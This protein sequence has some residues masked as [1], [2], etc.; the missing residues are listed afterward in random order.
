MLLF[1][2]FDKPV[3]SPGCRDIDIPVASAVSV[4]QERDGVFRFNFLRDI[5]PVCKLILK[6]PNDTRGRPAV[7][8]RVHIVL[9]HLFKRITGFS[10][11]AA[12][13]ANKIQ[14][15]LVQGGY[16]V[17]TFV[18]MN[19]LNGHVSSLPSEQVE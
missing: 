12:L 15:A 10:D 9:E 3:Q 1:C 19:R 6:V 14:Q 13:V 7:T 4:P 11:D 2:V 18:L 8:L 5:S 17:T 16:L